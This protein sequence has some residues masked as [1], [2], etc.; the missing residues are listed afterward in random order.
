MYPISYNSF[1][2]F[3]KNSNLPEH[4]LKRKYFLLSSQG[5]LVSECSNYPLFP[6]FIDCDYVEISRYKSFYDGTS[7][8]ISNSTD[9]NVYDEGLYMLVGTTDGGGLGQLPSYG[10]NLSSTTISYDLLGIYGAGWYINYFSTVQYYS[11]ESATSPD[12]VTTWTTDKG[13]GPRPDVIQGP[14]AV[15]NGTRILI[16]RTLDP[17]QYDWDAHGGEIAIKTS[18]GWNY[19]T[20]PLGTIV[21]DRRY[22]IGGSSYETHLEYLGYYRLIYLF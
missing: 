1:K 17:Q 21:R 2:N 18:I 13:S 3:P 22:L 6:D 20:Q 7:I 19:E 8:Q 15:S 4:E 16:S 10:G 14:S 9:L 12:L 5:K 11:L